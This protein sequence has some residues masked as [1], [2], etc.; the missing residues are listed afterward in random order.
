MDTTCCASGARR[1]RAAIAVVNSLGAVD[2]VAAIVAE[3]AQAVVAEA[4]RHELA[5]QPSMRVLDLGDGPSVDDELPEPTGPKAVYFWGNVDA[6]IQADPEAFAHAMDALCTTITDAPRAWGE[7][8]A[9]RVVL[10]GGSAL[11]SHLDGL[12]DCLKRGVRYRYILVQ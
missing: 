1:S 9:R 4:V 11:L 6:A 7:H 8:V 3:D 10:I 5:A 2:L 12:A